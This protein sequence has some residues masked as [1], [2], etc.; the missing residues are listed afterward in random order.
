MALT[1][2]GLR[3]DDVTGKTRE[4][5]L[6]IML[7]EGM[8]HDP[9]GAYE[10]AIMEEGVSG[11][12]AG[13]FEPTTEKIPGWDAVDDAGSALGAGDAAAEGSEGGGAGTGAQARDRG[14][15]D[16]GR[17]EPRGVADFKKFGDVERP[18]TDPALSVESRLAD[19]TK[20][21]ASTDAA[22]APS[23]AEAAAGE[24]DKLLADMLPTLSEDERAIFEKRLAELEQDKAAREQMIREGAA[25][26][27]E[28]AA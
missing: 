8:V 18:V 7:R 22:K 28:A 11:A 21:P 24:A 25:C 9:V 2:E 13:E 26:L 12:E 20:D 1:R 5:T 6:E 17:T 10:R 14:E 23:A 4:R 16:R 19:E 27:A 3:P 15:A